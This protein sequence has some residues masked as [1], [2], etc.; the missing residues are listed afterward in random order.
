MSIFDEY[1]PF[2][3]DFIYRNGWDE[4]RPIQVAAGDAIFHTDDNLLLTASTASGKTEA[5]FFP[6]LSL[7]DANPPKSVG[8][9]Y[10]GP[11]KALINDQF[12]RLTDLCSDGNIPIWHWHGDVSQSHKAKLM[13][14][15]SGILQ[16]TPESLEAI[17]LHKHMAVPR[18]FGDLRFVVIDEVHSLLRGDRGGQT[19]CLIERVSRLAGV[20]PRRIG[21]SATMGDPERTGAFLSL[22]TGRRTII[23]RIQSKGSRWRLSLEHFYVKDTQAGEGRT[24]IKALPVLDEK[25]DTAPR[26]ADPGLGYIF[27]H[28]RG[29]K[30]LVFVNSRE[31]CE[32]VTTSLRQYCELNHEADRFL[33]HHGNLSA[34]YRETAEMLSLIHI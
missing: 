27:E 25:T 32:G 29:K 15:P 20:N 4:L 6:I 26:E 18:L 30:C 17:L 24:D 11:L 2:V 22:G 33:I 9:I 21:L 19:L 12:Q 28:T 3:Q 16:L 14:H 10:I 1:A 7:F 34:S 31:E 23:P 8:C 13:R 5:A